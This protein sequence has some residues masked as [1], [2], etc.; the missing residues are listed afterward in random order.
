MGLYLK[1]YSLFTKLL[2]L[3]IFLSSFYVKYQYVKNLKK[4]IY[5]FYLEIFCLIFVFVAILFNKLM[6]IFLTFIISLGILCLSVFSQLNKME[7]ISVFNPL[8]LEDL[9]KIT[10]ISSIIY[11][12]NEY[13]LSLSR[14]FSFFKFVFLDIGKVIICCVYIVSFMIVNENKSKKT[15]KDINKDNYK[16]KNE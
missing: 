6:S 14:L 16:L 10:S 13:F 12:K 4:M 15:P 3:S 5:S 1:I 9:L 7:K 8:L 2:F 11:Q